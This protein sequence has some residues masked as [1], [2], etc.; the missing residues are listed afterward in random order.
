MIFSDNVPLDQELALKRAA[1]ERGVLV[2]GPDCGTASWAASGW[3]SPTPPSPAR[4]ASSPPPAPAASSCSAS[5]T[6]PAS[7]SRTR[8][9]WAAATSPPRCAA[10]PP[11]PPCAGSTP[12]PRVE[13]IVLVSKPPADDVADEIRATPP[14]WDTPVEFALLGAGPTTDLTAA[15]EACAGQA[16]TRATD[17]AR[18]GR[19]HRER[20]SPAARTVRGRPAATSRCW[21]P[22][23]A[24][25][26]IRSNIPLSPE[27]ALDADLDAALTV[28]AHTMVDFGDDALTRRDGRTR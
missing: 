15:A 6:T 16:G 28:D 17:L 8:S 27:L 2:M 24:L 21:S 12:T 1:A 23:R 11:G 10:S 14:G 18:A 13:L 7:G 3:A 26:P 25:G 20:W 4:S 5:S 9:G 22:P 19:G